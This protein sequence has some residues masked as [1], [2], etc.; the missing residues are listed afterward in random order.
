MR[1]LVL[2]LTSG[3]LLPAIASAHGRADRRPSSHT[4]AACRTGSPPVGTGEAVIESGGLTRRYLVHAPRRDDPARSA[5]L[6]VDLHGS[7]STPEEE[8]AISGLAAASGA[9]GAIV[10]APAAV[11]PR[12]GGGTAWNVPRDPAGADDVRFVIDMVADVVRRFCADAQ[13]V[14]VTGF[15]GGARLASAVACD[16]TAS[17]AALAAVGGLRPPAASCRGVV[18]VI[19]FHGTADRVNPYGGGGP[20]YWGTGVQQALAGWAARNRCASTAVRTSVPGGADRVVYGDCA[21][22]ADVELYVLRGV[23]HVW[24]GSRLP[25]PEALGPTSSFGATA[26]MLRFFERYGLVSRHLRGAS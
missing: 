4:D 24:P 22:G 20:V 19:A 6:I 26:T 12:S 1:V 17:I 5:P 7:G 25:L 3:L 15:S 16:R 21:S 14:F 10:V 8:L 23:G 18:P 2:V 11:M 9:Y 13:R